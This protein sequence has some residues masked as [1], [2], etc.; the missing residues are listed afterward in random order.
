MNPGEGTPPPRLAG[1][2]A[3][4]PGFLGLLAVYLFIHFALRLALSS[5]VGVDDVAESIFAQSL[6]W[7]YYPRQPP[8]FTWLMWGGF[9]LFGVG[10]AAIVAVK[11]TLVALAYVFFYLSAR[12]IFTD[13]A[14]V[15]AAALSPSLIYAIGW[16]VHVGFTNTVLLTAACSATFYVFLRLCDRGALSDY[17]WL[18][19]ALGAGLLSKWGF[20]AFAGSLLIAGLLQETSRRRLLDRRMFVTLAVAA[21]LLAPFV[22][23]GFSG[24]RVHDV[25]QADMRHGGR[26]PFFAG[27]VAGIETLAVAVAAFLAPLWVLG[28]IVFPKTLT[29]ARRPVASGLDARRLL[30]HFFL[31]MAL[32]LLAG[33]FVFGITFFKSRWMHPVLL[34]FPFYFFC[35]VRDSGFSG[36]QMRVWA[37]VLVFAAL[38]AVGMR[39][40]QDVIGPPFCGKCRLLKP[41]PELAREIGA[42]GFTGGT[43]VAADEHIAGNFRMV[44][45]KARVATS[46]YKFYVPPPAAAGDGQCL[47][48]WDARDGDRVPEKLAAFLDEKFGAVAGGAPQSVAAPY[49]HD[50]GRTL[51]LDFEILPGAGTCR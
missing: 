14:L 21:V 43:I 25:F 47:V 24:E 18:G 2:L 37:G 26:I 46:K 11:Y 28:L 1:I 8:L 49:R 19:A 30:E 33:V 40:A 51:R 45:P 9:E 15:L 44:F 36:R 38:A 5:T 41:Y 13:R 35:L 32:V 12:Q 4:W 34:L 7:T 50:E 10:L 17:F 6:Q 27:A 16:G 31:I 3:T 20:P 29:A 22:I 42:R 48:V 23:W 39:L